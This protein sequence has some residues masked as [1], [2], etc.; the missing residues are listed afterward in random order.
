VSSPPLGWR[1]PKEVRFGT[2]DARWIRYLHDMHLNKR[3]LP[4]NVW[5]TTGRVTQNGRVELTAPGYG[6]RPYGNGSIYV[7]WVDV[8]VWGRGKEAA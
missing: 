8:A 5:F 4:S 6:G 3:G 7:H 2:N 1:P